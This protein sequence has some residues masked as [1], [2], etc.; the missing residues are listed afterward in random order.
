FL[1]RPVILVED[2]IFIGN[3]KKTVAAAKEAIHS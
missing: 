2:K 3:S 1:K